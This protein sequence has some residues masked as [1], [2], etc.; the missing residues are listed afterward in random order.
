MSLD[1]WWTLLRWSW[2]DKRITQDHDYDPEWLE[3]WAPECPDGDPQRLC[4]ILG[5]RLKGADYLQLRVVLGWLDGGV[6]RAVVDEHADRVVVR[7]LACMV[8]EPPVPN[9][10]CRPG[11]TVDCPCNVPLDAPLGDRAVIDFDSGD[12]LPL[13]IPRWGTDERSVYVPRPEGSLWPPDRAEE[14]LMASDPTEER[15]M[16]SNKGEDETSG[17]V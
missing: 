7:A 2:Q 13:F 5:F 12:P 3:R 8:D 9:E 1:D 6:C 14:R 16:A 15:L 11:H 4:T 17:D 10:F